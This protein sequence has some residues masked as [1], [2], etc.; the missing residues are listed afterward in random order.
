MFALTL[1]HD[2][3]RVVTKEYTVVP[4]HGKLPLQHRSQPDCVTPRIAS[5][6]TTS[7]Y[8]LKKLISG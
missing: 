7:S 2:K 1:H 8:Y 3:K 5:D 4:P 6:T